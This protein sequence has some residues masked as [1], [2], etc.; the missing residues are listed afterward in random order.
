MIQKLSTKTQFSIRN[1]NKLTT[2]FYEYI[3][4]KNTQKYNTFY[5]IVFNI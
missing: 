3:R 4:H 1:V 2:D 5:N